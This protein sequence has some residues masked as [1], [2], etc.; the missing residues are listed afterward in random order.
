[1][2]NGTFFQTARSFP[3]QIKSQPTQPDHESALNEEMDSKPN[4]ATSALAEAIDDF[5]GELERKFKTVS[6]EILT[7]RET[8]DHLENLTKEDMRRGWMLT[9]PQ[10][11]KWPSVVIALRR[12]C[13]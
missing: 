9:T 8:I 13:L 7:K 4:E 12:N 5:L 11:T 10:W 1:M 2:P 3:S 6:G